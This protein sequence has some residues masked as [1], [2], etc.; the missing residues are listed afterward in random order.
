MIVSGCV[1]RMVSASDTPT[2]RA[3]MNASVPSTMPSERHDISAMVLDE[4]GG[5]T[6]MSANSR[7]NGGV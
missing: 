3:Q 4:T 6:L 2:W 1:E 7:V 5:G